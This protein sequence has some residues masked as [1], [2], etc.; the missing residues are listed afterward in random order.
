MSRST[1]RWSTG[2]FGVA[3][4]ALVG[5][6]VG[7]ALASRTAELSKPAA[8]AQSSSGV[9]GKP[10]TRIKTYQGV[11]TV[12]KSTTFTNVIGAI[13]IA[14]SNDKNQLIRVRF[15][16]STHCRAMNNAGIGDVCLVRFLID[17]TATSVNPFAFGRADFLGSASMEDWRAIF[18][19]PGD[20]TV[21]VQARTTSSD[22]WFYLNDWTVSVERVENV[23]K[24]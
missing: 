10:L 8:N 12:V 17:G 22:V 6:A 20:H 9:Q 3:L 7:Q 15:S 23:E 13:P 19:D 24:I 18:D 14:T 16:A 5:I 4:V 2:L 1:K 11:A 21:A